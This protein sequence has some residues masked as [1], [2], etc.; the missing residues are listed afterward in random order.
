LELHVENRAYVERMPPVAEEALKIGTLERE[1]EAVTVAGVVRTKPAK[2][3]V[4]TGKSEKVAVASFELE[5]DSGRIW[6]S[7]WRKHA[8][9]AGQLTVGT[10]IT[11]K[12]AYV[13]KGFGDALEIS[14]RASSKIEIV[15]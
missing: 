5:D 8:E 1:E 15:T 14:T 7:A 4:T 11:I 6:V 9:I 2:R 3:E 10:R 12:D 13:R